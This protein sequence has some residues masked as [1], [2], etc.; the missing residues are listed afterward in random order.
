MHPLSIHGRATPLS[1]G[2]GACRP[3]CS[4]HSWDSRGGSTIIPE[5]PRSYGK[6]KPLKIPRR[7]V[8]RAG[9]RLGPRPSD[10]TD[11]G[12]G[13][14]APGARNAC[15]H[16]FH[17]QPSNHFHAG[18]ASG[19]NRGTF[20]FPPGRKWD[21]K[22]L[23]TD[24][25]PYGPQ[26]RGRQLRSLSDKASHE[27]KRPNVAREGY[28][29]ALEKSLSE[30]ASRRVFGMFLFQGAWPC[31]LHGTSNGRAFPFPRAPRMHRHPGKG[32]SRKRA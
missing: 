13:A 9:V 2:G 32:E 15:A 29:F 10:S 25:A 11:R 21:K 31:L 30:C 8:P 16:V 3:S 14:A 6:L 4:L 28:G 19:R 27:E 18:D 26:A 20:R 22:D 7:P 1:E 17:R 23:P 5:E 24:C 12:R